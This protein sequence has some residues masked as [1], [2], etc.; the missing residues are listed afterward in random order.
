MNPPKNLVVEALSRSP[1]N[2]HGPPPR[3]GTKAWRSLV[4]W[5]LLFIVADASG[6]EY[7]TY[8][9]VQELPLTWPKMWTWQKER[10]RN[11]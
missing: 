1:K 9:R 5:H 3:L 11:R 8:H 2:Q 6:W 10:E 4:P 7:E